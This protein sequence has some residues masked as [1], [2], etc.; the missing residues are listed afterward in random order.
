MLSQGIGPSS[1][2]LSGRVWAGFSLSSIDAI[3]HMDISFFKKLCLITGE[4]FGG[5]YGGPA[6][7]PQRNLNGW[8]QSMTFMETPSKVIYWVTT[9]LL[10]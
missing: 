1:S 5:G 8:G 6:Y 10:C 2:V 9:L 4:H 7:S 3:F